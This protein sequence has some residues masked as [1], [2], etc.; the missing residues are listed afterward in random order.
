[1][2]EA[3]GN[4]IASCSILGFIPDQ[5]I[6]ILISYSRLDRFVMFFII[7]GAI[8]IIILGIVGCILPVIPGPPIAFIGVLMIYFFCDDAISTSSIVISAILTVVTIILDYLIPSLGVKYFGGTKYGKWGSFI[9][10]LVGLFFLPWGLIA[11][12]FLGAIVG[13]IV[14]N[15]TGSTAIKS[16]IGSLM[17]FLL[18]VL[19]KFIVCVYFLVIAVI[20]LYNFIVQSYFQ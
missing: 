8:V 20:V 16:G 7:F 9:G 1:M 17:G 19:F 14:G 15:S 2:R 13:E 5:S 18:G 11:G 10:T 3:I 6:L 12:P 4:P